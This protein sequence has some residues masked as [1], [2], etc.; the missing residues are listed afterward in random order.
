ML[1][2]GEGLRIRLQDRLTKGQEFGA[3]YSAGN[4]VIGK[5][6]ET[7]ESGG[8]VIKGA[9]R[10]FYQ[11]LLDVIDERDP[12]RK[13]GEEEDRR[14]TVC[15]ITILSYISQLMDK[16]LLLGDSLAAGVSGHMAKG[17][18]QSTLGHLRLVPRVRLL[19]LTLAPFPPPPPPRGRGDVLRSHDFARGL[20]LHEIGDG[21]GRALRVD[22]GD[23][24][25]ESVNLPLAGCEGKRQS[26]LGRRH[27][28]PPPPRTKSLRSGAGRLR[29]KEPPC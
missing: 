10:K 23:A 6:R 4:K 7:V 26:A 28:H 24:A 27:R 1:D 3:R 25:E 8:E 16:I 20:R 19:P 18:T 13:R 12:N 15:N 14:W 29:Q 17:A 9:F 21:G 11:R 2:D 22:V 5:I